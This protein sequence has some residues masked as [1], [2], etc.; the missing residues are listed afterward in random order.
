MQ[1]ETFQQ[2]RPN[3]EESPASTA[4]SVAMAS[5]RKEWRAQLAAE[6]RELYDETS[7]ETVL[8]TPPAPA[9]AK[10]LSDIR[11]LARELQKDAELW[12]RVHDASTL[13]DALA[14]L[15]RGDGAADGQADRATDLMRALCA[16]LVDA[17]RGEALLDGGRSAK[18]ISIVERVA[19]KKSLLLEVP[20]GEL[21]LIR[22]QLEQ[23]FRKVYLSLR[24]A[25]YLS[26]LRYADDFD[27]KAVEALQEQ[28]GP[29]A[30][31]DLLYRLATKL[32]FVAAY[33]G[34]RGGR[35]VTE[36]WSLEAAQ[37]SL[38]YAT[39]RE[40]LWHV[41]ST[42]REVAPELTVGQMGA[43]VGSFQLALDGHF[44]GD[45]AT[46]LREN[47]FVLHDALGSAAQKAAAAGSG[48]VDYRSPIDPRMQA[49]PNW[50]P[51]AKPTLKRHADGTPVNISRLSLA[52]RS[53][54][55]QKLLQEWMIRFDEPSS[56]EEFVS[57]MTSRILPRKENQYTMRTQRRIAK[58]VKRARE[59]AFLPYFTPPNIDPNAETYFDVFK[60][61]EEL[62]MEAADMTE[63]QAAV[64]E[65]FERFK[66]D[67]PKEM[68]AAA[69]PS[70]AT[71]NMDKHIREE[72]KAFV[73]ARGTRLRAAEL[74]D[75]ARKA[76]EQNASGSEASS[77]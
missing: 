77:V 10:V 18:R 41:S 30:Y 48:W 9:M 3:Y 45:V 34:V 35:S 61:V 20:V 12:S 28:L 52:K 21:V 39:L 23:A 15:I 31:D 62:E 26:K 40:A 50:D 8:A 54:F 2:F 76:A 64:A 57:A 75:E 42:L 16:K 32:N 36:L 56:I 19:I 37:L 55:N 38:Q 73:E 47:P 71:L 25:H 66:K 70:T 29:S 74:A 27:T 33:D 7:A 44:G 6:L 63:E 43:A 22:T 17:L 58:Q 49:D 5:V 53:K 46:G 60:L 51:F 1:A 4:D 14:A 72:Y 67:E 65:N 69:Q 13:E 11:K 59:M 24:E 68:A